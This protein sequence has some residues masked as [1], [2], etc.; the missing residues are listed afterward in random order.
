MQSLQC[1][2]NQQW[3]FLT[4]CTGNTDC[5]II[6]MWNSHFYTN[7]PTHSFQESDISSTKTWYHRHHRYGITIFSSIPYQNAALI[8]LTLGSSVCAVHTTPSSAGS[9]LKTHFSP[10]DSKLISQPS[11]P[12]KDHWCPQSTHGA[13]QCKLQHKDAEMSTEKRNYI[14]KNNV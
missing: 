7:S 12:Q 8:R 9:K 4:E 14:G 5:C 1:S 3:N 10:F 13:S 11:Q 6:H 2:K